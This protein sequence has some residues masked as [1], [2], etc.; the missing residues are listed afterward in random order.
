MDADSV[1]AAILGPLGALAFAAMAYWLER[2]SHVETRQ[3]CSK[4][5]QQLV[6]NLASMDKTLA[7]FAEI[8]R[9]IQH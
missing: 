9:S 1:M 8:V 5:R 6:A 4:E 2:K 3:E 7:G